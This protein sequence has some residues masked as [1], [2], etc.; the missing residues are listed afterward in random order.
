M[1]TYRAAYLKGGSG[2]VL[3]GPEHATLTDEQ[4]LAEARRELEKVGVG[5]AFDTVDAAMEAVAIGDWQG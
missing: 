3:T 4:L 5:D 2:T 1:A